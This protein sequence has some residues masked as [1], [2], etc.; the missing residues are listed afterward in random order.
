MLRAIIT[1]DDALKTA[2]TTA[3]DA[4]V[5]AVLSEESETQKWNKNVSSPLMYRSVF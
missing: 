4:V 5:S 3:V 2:Q 1:H